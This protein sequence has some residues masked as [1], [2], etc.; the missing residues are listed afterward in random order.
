MD[1]TADNF[2]REGEGCV[3]CQGMLAKSKHDLDEYNLDELICRIKRENKYKEYD[4]LIG[5]SGGVDSS[6][7]LHK[8]VELGL[9]PLVIHVD[10]GWNTALS[11]HNIEKLVIGTR[12]TYLSEILYWPEYKDHL[13]AMLE[14][15]VVDLELLADNIMNKIILET[16]IKYKIR[17]ILN[18]VNTATE[19]ISLPQNWAWNK[20]DGLNLRSILETHSK[21]RL[22][23]IQPIT[24]SNFYI[25]KKIYQI[26]NIPFLNYVNF[27]KN[28]ALSEL[29]DQYNFVPYRYKHYENVFTRF[30]QAFLLP[31][32]FN[33]DKRKMH[34]SALIVSGEMTRDQAL[35]ELSK[36]P[37]PS[38]NLLLRDK[39][40]IT[41]K[42]NL[43]H[44]FF[45]EYV[46]RPEISH[47]NYKT[48]IKH[49]KKIKHL[50]KLEVGF[51]K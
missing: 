10:N 14:S 43:E 21:S 16:A 6:Y 44:N 25:L 35:C 47:T 27:S 41:K 5:L 2:A 46:K 7:V 34:L 24:A 11:Q 3:F 33:I 36:S 42:L 13:R 8:S 29:K 38:K 51:N 17:Y 37:Y 26:K 31:E 45:S 23:K 40:F 20:L 30:Y 12:A 22:E 28:Q 48:Y 18:G 4:C 1:D 49:M 32:K 9:R 19:G 39:K 15:N 50:L